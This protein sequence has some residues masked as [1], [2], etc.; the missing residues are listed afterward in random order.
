MHTLMVVGAGLILLATFVVV[1][2]LAGHGRL[3]TRLFVPVWL[4]ATLVNLYIGVTR[5]GYTVAQEL[6]IQLIVFGVPVLV[7][8]VISRRL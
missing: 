6:P 7:A 2:Y 4:L 5:A 1:G 3:A 8:Y